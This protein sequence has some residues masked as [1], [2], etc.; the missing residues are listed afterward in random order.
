[1][2]KVLIATTEGQGVRE[3]DFAWAV[4]GELVYIPSDVCRNPACGCER[5]FAG[6]AS[7]RASTT[8]LVVERPDISAADL[9]GALSDSLERQGWISGGSSELDRIVF[10]ELYERLVVAAAH[11]PAGSVLE[12]SGDH[13]WRRLQTEPM[14][15]PF[16]LGGD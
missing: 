14:R 7:S 12:R 15:S 8:A 1:M 16:R 11:F 10:G 6:M 3:G 5:G 2:V 13:I 4:D 9:R